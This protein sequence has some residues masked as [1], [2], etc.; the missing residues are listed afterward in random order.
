MT[1]TEKIASFIYDFESKDVPNEALAQAKSAIMDY[2]GVTLAGL[3]EECAKIVRRIA[4]A[5]GGN[6]QAT[7]WG[8]RIKT[9]AV[10]AALAN[11]TAAHALDLDSAPPRA[12][13]A[14]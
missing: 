9:S 10:L 2:T 11:G 13:C 5:M 12:F 1:A 4:R 8:D 3:S 14:R 7:V 6:P